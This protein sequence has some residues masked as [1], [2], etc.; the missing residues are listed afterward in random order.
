MIFLMNTL[1][2]VKMRIIFN[3]FGF[4]LIYTFIILI[5]YILAIL[6]KKREHKK[7]ILKNEIDR[8]V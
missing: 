2:I 8:N 7:K 4:V 1:L 5:N 6:K 3:Y